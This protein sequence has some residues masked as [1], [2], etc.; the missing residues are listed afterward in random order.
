ME[1]LDLHGVRHSQ[2]DEKIRCFLNFV[3]LPCEIV[4]GNSSE[5]KTIARKIIK[6]YNWFC[7]ERDS[8]NHGTLIVTEDKI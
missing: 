4:T 1:T 8:Y 6:E 5:M 7:H 3:D 2:V